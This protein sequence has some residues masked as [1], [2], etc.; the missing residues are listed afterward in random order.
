VFLSDGAAGNFDVAQMGYLYGLHAPEAILLTQL[1][2][3]PG[4]YSGWKNAAFEEGYRRIGSARNE[5][6]RKEAFDAME[7]ALFGDAPVA[8]L[9]YRNQAFLISP[10]LKGWRDNAVQQV[11]WRALGLAP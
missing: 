5:A 10:H 1:G 3:S 8:P 6:E 2:D 4:N 11:D 7:R 9:Y